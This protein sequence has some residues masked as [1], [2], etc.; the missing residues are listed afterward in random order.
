MKT[1]NILATRAHKVI[2][3]DGDTA[4]KVFD[5]NFP[6]TDVLNEALNQARVEE[7]GLD[8]PKIHSVNVTEDGKWCIV[9]DYVEEGKTLEQIMEEDPANLEKY[10]KEFVALQLEVHSKRAPPLN[11]LKDKWDSK[12]AASKAI[13]ATDP[14]RVKD[15]PVWQVCQSTIRCF[16]GTLTQVTSSWMQRAG[17]T[18]STG[19]MR[20]R[21]T[22][23]Q[24]RQLHYLL[25]A[26][27]DQKLAELYLELV[28]R[29]GE[30][31]QNS[32][33]GKLLPISR[34]IQTG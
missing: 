20:P 13:N 2:Y 10:M 8:I 30:I 9:S 17:I 11:K 22:L 18:S 26:L 14:L 4:V 7:T 33:C 12:I 15:T 3:R 25:F 29:Y 24:M 21:A 34:S 16:M 31:P 32:T 23:L 27:K 5:A 6:K 28:L 19:P 1:E